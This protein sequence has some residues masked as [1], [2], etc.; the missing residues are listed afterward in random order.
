MKTRVLL[1][2][3]AISLLFGCRQQVQSIEIN[4]N[5]SISVAANSKVIV[6]ANDESPEKWEFSFDDDHFA[7]FR[8]PISK[9][10]SV[11]NSDLKEAFKKNIDA[12]IQVFDSQNPDS[13]YTFNYK[14]S[15]CD[16]SFDNSV[17]GD[18]YKFYGRFL[19]DEHDFI[20]FCFQTPY[21][22]DNYSE[23]TKDKLFNSIVIK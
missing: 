6:S 23:R 1:L 2:L 10:D 15:Q 17:S 18:K 21:P 14:Y 16:L 8:Y 7:V 9:A 22:V 4:S 19:E 20:A 5:V 13:I 11:S 12:F 3:P